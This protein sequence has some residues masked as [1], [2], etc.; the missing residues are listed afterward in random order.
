MNVKQTANVGDE[1]ARKT[2]CAATRELTL[3]ALLHQEK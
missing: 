2:L 1:P 3:V